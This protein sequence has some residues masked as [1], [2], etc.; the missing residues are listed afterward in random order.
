[1]R[2]NLL[3]HTMQRTAYILIALCFVVSCSHTPPRQ[4][5]L[6]LKA[7]R[8]MESH[9]DSVGKIVDRIEGYRRFTEADRALYGLLSALTRSHRDS[10]ITSDSLLRPAARYFATHND[11]LRAASAFFYLSRYEQYRRHAENRARA[12]MQASLFAGRSGDNKLKGVVYAEKSLLFDEEHRLDSALCYARLSLAAYRL[13]GNRPDITICLIDIGRR[14]FSLKRYDEALRW[15]TG[16]R[17]YICVTR[18]TVLLSSAL[19]YEGVA[20]LYL[21]CYD[22][23]RSLFYRAIRTSTDC[24]DAGKW[25]NLGSL[26]Q[27]TGRYDSAVICFKRVIAL[28]Q[29]IYNTRDSY[30]KLAAIAARQGRHAAAYR[31]T[32]DFNRMSDSIRCATLEHGW[33]DLE[34]RYRLQITQ[35][36][37]QQLQLTHQRGKIIGLTVL[38]L[39]SLIAV[40]LLVLTLRR[41]KQLFRQQQ[42]ILEKEQQLVRQEQE[43]NR[44]L[45]RQ[46][47]IRTS[48]LHYIN[49]HQER[50]NSRLRE[51][52]PSLKRSDIAELIR[53]DEQSMEEHLQALVADVDARH[54]GLSQRLADTYSELTQEDIQI[55]CLLV[56]GVD[57]ST[58]ATW[59]HIK[60]GSFHTRRSRLRRKLD[61]QKEDDLRTFLAT[62]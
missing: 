22:K 6:L 58:I 34:N 30:E 19:R 37:Y 33:N 4:H 44:L 41:R 18:D 23:A 49:D 3:N 39:I 17:N 20:N 45:T 59:Y 47:E 5:Y 25:L 52:T 7:E 62:F 9:P 38:L 61:L 54:N 24:Y 60:N 51:Q 16:A 48:T 56:A 40:S 26:Y 50:L 10:A 53:Q 2:R 57:S 55:C 14:Y 36:E 1:M 8:L 15:F 11:P 46:L 35:N 43:K 21:G 27:M 12:L 42:L 28:R 13:T 29:S 31:Y 32:I